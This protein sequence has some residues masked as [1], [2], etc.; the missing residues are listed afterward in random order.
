MIASVFSGV[1]R[2]PFTA[3][4]V[5]FLGSVAAQ[6]ASAADCPGHPDAIGTSRT[7]VVDPRA[8]PIIGTMQYNKTL[9]LE[10]HE[11][12]L[13]FDDGPTQLGIDN[14]LPELERHGVKATF[15]V[16]ALDA[17]NN[18]PQIEAVLRDGHEIAARGYQQRIENEWQRTAWLAHHIWASQVGY[19][20]APKPNQL[21][22]GAFKKAR[23]RRPQ[24][25]DE[26]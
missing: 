13:T 14:V 8:H 5:G 17:E 6:A 12:V 15:F 23:R 2:R 16:P 20:K 25:P 22:G 1:W 7:I 21:L 4:C 26:D 3:L 18:R 11:V 19:K 9:P 10:D 24:E